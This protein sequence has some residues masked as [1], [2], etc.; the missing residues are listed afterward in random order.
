MLSSERMLHKDYNRKR[1]VEKKKKLMAVR[2]KGL[3]AKTN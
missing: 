2:L 1:S 3:A